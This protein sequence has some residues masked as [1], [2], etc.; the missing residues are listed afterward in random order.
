M[1]NRYN[2][3]DTR[4]VNEMLR[5]DL[6]R[7]IASGV[8]LAFIAE[9]AGVCRQTV[10]G[11]N[12]GR[13]QRVTVAVHGLLLD[14]ID[15]IDSGAIVVPPHARRP[16]GLAPVLAT[17]D[18]NRCGYGHE[19]TPDNV[20]VL[21]CGKRVC[22]RCETRRTKQ[23][24]LR[25]I[26]KDGDVKKCKYG[27]DLEGPAARIRVREGVR[28]GKVYTWTECMACRAVPKKHLT[29]EERDWIKV[30]YEAGETISSLAERYGVSRPTIYNV[31]GKGK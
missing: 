30:Y 15:K 17:T 3:R 13:L 20:R 8:R 10:S 27:H 21:P 6:Q 5:G 2:W 4:D 19:R 26:R 28:K 18:Q 1:G 14:V 16:V 12:S 22:I 31:L 25:Q 11:V 9:Q 29:D 24:R 7:T 23:Y